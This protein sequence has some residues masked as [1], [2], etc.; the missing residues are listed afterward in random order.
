[1]YT[2]D[3]SPSPEVPVA[4]KGKKLANTLTG[5]LQPD[6]SCTELTA[7]PA[8][9][10]EEPDARSNLPARWVSEASFFDV[11]A[12]QLIERLQPMDSLYGGALP[13]AA[14]PL[15]QQGVPLPAL[16]GSCAA[17]ACSTSGAATA[18]TPRRWPGSAHR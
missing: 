1:M 10:M 12:Q 6:P 9:G 8:E 13:R 15:V 14:A 11:I 17:S 16:L 3:N 5:L 7:M 2:G 18:S 4:P